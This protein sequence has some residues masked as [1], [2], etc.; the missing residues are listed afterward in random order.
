MRLRCLVLLATLATGGSV[1]AQGGAPL[2]KSMSGRWVAVVPGSQTYTDSIAAVLDAPDG[3]GTVTGRLT[4]RGVAC[5]SIDEPLTG[6]WDGNELRFESQVRPN[7]NAARM[8]GQCGTG[9]ATFTLTRKTGPSGFQGE[10]I[11]DGMQA[12]RQVTLAP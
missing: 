10:F 6:T 11:R 2:P 12:P 9:H 7:V 8:N 1:L 3:T 5:G 4:V